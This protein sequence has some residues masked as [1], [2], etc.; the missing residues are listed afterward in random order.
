M[1]HRQSSQFIAFAAV[2]LFSSVQFQFQSQSPSHPLAPLLGLN[3]QVLARRQIRIRP[4]LGSRHQ[5]LRRSKFDLR[6]VVPRHCRSRKTTRLFKCVYDQHIQRLRG[7]DIIIVSGPTF[8]GVL[9]L[10][11]LVVVF[12]VSSSSS[13]YSLNPTGIL[14]LRSSSHTALPCFFAYFFTSRSPH[15]STLRLTPH[16]TRR[17]TSYGRISQHILAVRERNDHSPRLQVL[18]PRMSRPSRDGLR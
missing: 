6:L 1:N 3:F 8:F 13:L 9:T 16:Y 18:V 17:L 11:E 2:G 4:F 5:H 7:L 14:V 10:L 15:A 12:T